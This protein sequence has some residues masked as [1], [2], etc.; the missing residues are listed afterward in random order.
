M[1]KH[2]ALLQLESELGGY[3]QDMLQVDELALAILRGHLEIEEALNDIMGVIFFHPQELQGGRFNFDRKVRIIKAAALR[4]RGPSAWSMVEAVN[5]LRNSFSHLGLEGKQRE[6]MD[7]LLQIFLS[8]M[9]Q[10]TAERFR[11][12]P[13]HVIV[14]AACASCAGFLG[15]VEDGLRQ[16]RTVLN[17]WNERMHPKERRYPLPPSKNGNDD[18]SPDNGNKA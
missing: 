11:D 6:R 3:V 16:Q 1:E 17:E 15:N 18:G 4:W 7:R 10:E 5:D 8:F 12:A 2:P 9:K 14:I 13:N